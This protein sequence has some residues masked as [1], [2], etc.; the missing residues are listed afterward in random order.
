MD[1]PS[2]FAKGIKAQWVTSFSYFDQF[3]PKVINMWHHKVISDTMLFSSKYQKRQM[4]FSWFANWIAK[5]TTGS[6]PIGSVIRLS[7]VPEDIFFL[8]TLI[9]RGEGASTR[10][11]A[12]RDQTV[13][14]VY[15]ILGI[16]GTHLWSQGMIRRAPRTVIHFS[17]ITWKHKHEYR[18]RVSEKIVQHTFRLPH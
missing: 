4:T 5:G 6:F 12:P 3:H 14:T 15:F 17:C 13:S 16:L 18:E 8:S 2:I 9:V 11:E 10:R 7:R 1:D